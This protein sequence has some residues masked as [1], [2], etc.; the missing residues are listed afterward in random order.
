MS[1]RGHVRV[2]VHRKGVILRRLSLTESTLGA[3]GHAESDIIP[4]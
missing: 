2:V 3:W 1:S 4:K